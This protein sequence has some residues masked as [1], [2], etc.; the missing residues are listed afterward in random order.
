MIEDQETRNR[1]TRE[2]DRNVIVQAS[3]GTGKT[4][5]I[6]ERVMTLIEGGVDLN[7]IAV[8]TFTELAAAELR[9]RIRQEIQERKKVEPRFK[10]QEEL[11]PAALITTIHGFASAILREN[12][13][14]TGVDPSFEITKSHFSEI[15]ITR[16]WDRYISNLDPCTIRESAD[17]LS[18]IHTGA[19]LDISRQI[20][21]KYWLKNLSCFGSAEDVLKRIKK[22]SGKQI[23]F[24]EETS[25]SDESDKLY[26]VRSSILNA[27]YEITRYPDCSL[28]KAE[29][30]LG[31]INL[32]GGRQK[33]WGGKEVLKEI[34]KT[35]GFLRTNLKESIQMLKGACVVDAFWDFVEPFVRILRTEWESDPSR[36]SFS[37]LLINAERAISENS[38]LRESLAARFKH[39][40]IDEFQDTSSLQVNIFSRILSVAENFLPGTLTVVGDPKQSIYGWRNADIETYK[41]TVEKL[42]NNNALFGSIEV[43]FR[44]SKKIVGF[45]NAFGQTL[46]DLQTEP[47]N[48]FSCPYLPIR[49]SPGADEGV[50]VKVLQ[51]PHE[52]KAEES[53]NLQAE[54]FAEFVENGIKKKQK[55]GD[56]ALLVRSR[57]HIE[58]FVNA[59]DSR[60]LQYQVEAGRDFKTRQEIADLREMIRCILSP[61][62]GLAWVHTIR[63]PF[64][65]ID[66]V[67]ITSAI[68]GGTTGYLDET[69][70]CPEN[71][72]RA[73]YLL[74]SLRTASTCLSL[75]DFLSRILLDTDFLPVLATSGHELNRRLG[76]LQYLL[77][78]T[79]SG[80]IRDCSQLL[81]LLR[82]DA[83]FSGIE[84]PSI[85][86]ADNSVVVS[87]I[88]RAKGLEFKHVVLAAQQSSRAGTDRRLITY[89]HEKLA[90]VKL[91]KNIYTPFWYDILETRKA[92][93]TAENRRLLYVAVT[94]AI[95]SLT[96][97][98]QHPGK[99]GD[100]ILRQALLKAA[101]KNEDCYVLEELKKQE[102]KHEKPR[103]FKLPPPPEKRISPAALI[104]PLQ[105]PSVEKFSKEIRLGNAVH[106]IMEKIDFRN[107][108]EWLKKNEEKLH[109]SFE[110]IYEEA[111]YMVLRFFR[112]N[113]PFRISDCS[114][115]GREY[116]YTVRTDA[117]PQE[118]YI[119]LLLKKGDE[120]I[121]LDYKTDSPKPE[122]IEAL[123]EKYYLEKQRF[124]GKD[125]ARA[126]NLPVKVY[127]VFLGSGV[128]Y[129][130][131]AT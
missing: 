119:D 93:E 40:L 7:N 38:L 59:L 30:F 48:R 65:G 15:E 1:I 3:A 123:V 70:T 52:M 13:H 103:Y 68:L 108:E 76:N 89:D 35:V 78:R 74:R 17:L 10:K 106:R 63:S 86:S 23:I 55:A 91:D 96:I 45:V 95:E 84:E 110:E 18:I 33:S 102:R 41:Q 113:F 64:F 47:E 66:D 53:F 14:L 111:R 57:T 104:F 77:D 25:C 16:L 44:S 72:R 101:E 62:D 56:F 79:Y 90:A 50:P 109:T 54:W 60:K 49:P 114:V 46:F 82:E 98:V 130:V 116:P 97:F 39:I 19:L 128:V 34:K 22:K 131:Q 83:T 31:L 75:P 121:A 27:F 9:N 88:H 21:E 87:T 4:T 29:E 42:S 115:L 61:T 81:E 127:L 11:L 129:E 2:R 112:I 67:S 85:S 71:I 51:I 126:F 8:V 122:E 94:R 58:K 69:D 28:E 26:P 32:Q 125:I 20:E 100:E 107:H 6:I 80:E 36:L 117:G 43:N 24:L 120:L 73:N 92:R 124:Y 118:R 37:D 99:S 12:F 5:Q 105:I